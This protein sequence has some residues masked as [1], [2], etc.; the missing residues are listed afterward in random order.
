SNM[1]IEAEPGATFV[2]KHQGPGLY[3]ENCRNVQIKNL[4]LD[5]D[6]LPFTQGTITAVNHDDATFDLKVQEG[7]RDPA[8]PTFTR[9]GV[10]RGLVREPGSGLIDLTCGDPRIKRVERI[11]ENLY[12]LRPAN[13]EGVSSPELVK[14]FQTGKAFVLNSRGTPGNGAMITAVRSEYV[15]F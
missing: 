14:N 7:Y 15:T 4:A 10:L 8:T 2:M 11:G 1:V 9:A 12:R 6:P 5:C 3:I 13:N